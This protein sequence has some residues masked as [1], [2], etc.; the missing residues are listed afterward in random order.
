MLGALFRTMGPFAP[1][2]PPGASPAPLWGSE[3][4]LREL[5]GDRVEWRSLERDVLE[6]TAFKQPRDYGSTSRRTTAR[7]SASA[8]TRPSRAARRSST[9]RW[10]PSATTGTSGRPTQARFEKEFLVAVGTRA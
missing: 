4:H 10:T 2:P 3:A 5:F 8:P 7:R 1:P 9:P 6:I